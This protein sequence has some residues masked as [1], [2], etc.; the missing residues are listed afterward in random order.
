MAETIT[1]F[2]LL[3]LIKAVQLG[4]RPTEA[5]LKAALTT[6]EHGAPSIRLVRKALVRARDAHLISP[7]RG[8][9]NRVTLNEF[10]AHAVRYVFPVEAREVGRRHLGV[11]TAWSAQ[12]LR[13]R[14]RSGEAVVWLKAGGPAS[15]ELALEPLDPRVIELSSHDSEFHEWMALIDALRAGRAREVQIAREEVHRRLIIDAPQH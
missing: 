6:A 15:G 1:S 8:T 3:V 4:K 2:D 5:A 7:A 9:V 10:L 12:P 11:P 13:R 14:I